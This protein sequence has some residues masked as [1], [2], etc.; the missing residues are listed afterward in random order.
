MRKATSRKLA[1]AGGALT[2]AFAGILPIAAPASAAAQ[3]VP[4][5]MMDELGA[6]PAEVGTLASCS[7]W[8]PHIRRVIVGSAAVHT[9]Y[10]GSSTVIAHWKSKTLFR[11]DKRCV[12]DAG[13][14]WWHSDCCTGV[15]G[16]IWNDYTEFA[17]YN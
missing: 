14:L 8:T 6:V 1:A 7:D 9:S 3:P 12:N 4:A 2:L 13:N 5:A 17:H 10:S 16:W 11:I 15:K